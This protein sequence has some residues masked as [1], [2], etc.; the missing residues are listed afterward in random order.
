MRQTQP[1]TPRVSVVM[2]VRNGQRWLTEAA[3]SIL[4]QS[5]PALELIVVD[6][7]S[8][9]GT[10]R[11]LG[12]LA[13]RDARVR[14]FAQAPHGLAEALNRG[15]H[16]ARAPLIARLD[17][18]D[19]AHETRLQ[20][21]ADIFD[22]RPGLGVLGAWALE[23]DSRGRAMGSREPAVD[24]ASLAC[25]LTKSNPL[26]H[27]SIMA[28]TELLRGLGGYRV[29]FE[30]AEDYDLW[31]RASEV[32]E[33]AILPE[34]LVSYRR[35]PGSVSRRLSLRQAFSVRLAQRAAQS[36]R[37]RGGDPAERL[38]EPPDWRCAL[39]TNAFYADDVALYRWL[40]PG[41]GEGPSAGAALMDRLAELSHAERRLAARS[42]LTR[43]RSHD[44]SESV[45]ARGLLLRLFREQPSTVLRAAWSLRA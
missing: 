42:L 19:V 33:L 2:A 13:S 16:A 11:L 17:A 28:R 9:D 4:R 14:V 22:A 20:R 27:S 1:A 43:M 32:S 7:G 3:T 24:P 18:D 5:E 15:L 23:I 35:H 44:R 34:R 41:A 38:A 25:E 39:A 26:V 31:L 37:S 29:A 40:D 21:Q 8:T 30:G 45:N 12:E 36:R 10:S 6:D